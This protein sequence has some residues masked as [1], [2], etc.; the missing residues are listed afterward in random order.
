MLNEYKPSEALTSDITRA[1]ARYKPILA[2]S[3]S[4]VFLSLTTPLRL[5]TVGFSGL[6]LWQYDIPMIPA[7]AGATPQPVVIFVLSVIAVG[8]S[9]SFSPSQPRISTARSI[10]KLPGLMLIPGVMKTGFGPNTGSSVNVNNLL[11]PLKSSP[12]SSIKGTTPPRSQLNA[13]R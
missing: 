8:K 1:S 6:K 7:H 13:A 2:S 10:L 9:F 11:S 4:S 5:P 12:P 3:G